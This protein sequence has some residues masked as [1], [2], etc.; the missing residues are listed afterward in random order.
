MS[1]SRW[2]IPLSM[3]ILAASLTGCADPKIST[4]DLVIVNPSDAVVLGQGQR[5]LLGRKTATYV[6]PRPKSAFEAA[7][8]P[9]AIHVPLS[10]AV[11]ND[12]RLAGYDILIIYAEDYDSPLGEAMAKRLMALGYADVRLMR[13]GLR[14]WRDAGHAVEASPG[15]PQH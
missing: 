7:H 10:E 13:G 3:F 6:D 15:L 14:A 9:G 2:T 5:T 8:L 11:A 1:R 12:R 4:R